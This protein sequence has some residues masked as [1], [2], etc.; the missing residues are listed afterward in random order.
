MKVKNDANEESFEVVFQRL[1]K[2]VE[3]L[4]NENI[5]LDG[6]IV[7]FEQGMKDYNKC[8]EILIAAK[9]KI[10]MFEKSSKSFKEVDG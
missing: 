10:L 6:A 2:S 5:S 4:Q 3:A 9:Q 1:E 7:S 8:L